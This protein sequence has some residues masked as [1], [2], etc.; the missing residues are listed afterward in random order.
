MSVATILVR[1][2]IPALI[3]LKLDIPDTWRS[4]ET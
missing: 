3:P 2:A 4:S 1:V